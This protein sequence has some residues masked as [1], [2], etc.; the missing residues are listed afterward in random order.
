MTWMEVTICI[1]AKEE[2]MME[3]MLNFAN[4]DLLLSIERVKIVFMYTM[5]KS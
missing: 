4:K 3:D 1:V 2:D 5:N